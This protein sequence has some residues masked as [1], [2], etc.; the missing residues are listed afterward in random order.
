MNATKER[1]AWC[2]LQVKLCDPCLS[3][4]C[5]PWCKK[6]LYK[7]SSFPF[8]LHAAYCYRPRSVDCQSVCLSVTVVSPAKTAEPIEISFGIWTRVGQRSRVLGGGAHWRH[9]ANTVEP[10]T[11]HVR[12]RCGLLSDYFEHLYKFVDEQNQ[13]PEF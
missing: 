3:A 10:S 4:L 1:Q 6:T 5:V 7:Y 2:C 13:N 11:V 9:L 8:P 12:R